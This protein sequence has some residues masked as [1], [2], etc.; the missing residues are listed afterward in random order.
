M[1]YQVGRSEGPRPSF[2]AN[3]TLN[4][5]VDTQF[6]A[7]RDRWPLFAFAHNLG[8]VGV[9]RTTPIVYAIGHVRDPLIQLSGIPATNNL[10][11]SYYLTRYTSISDMASRPFFT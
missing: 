2:Q 10:R 7:V 4:N 3:G 5:T 8:T 9:T 6:R 1:T 11:G